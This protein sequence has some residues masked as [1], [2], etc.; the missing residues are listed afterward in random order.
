[1]GAVDRACILGVRQIHALKTRNSH[2]SVRL[3][4][5]SKRDREDALRLQEEAAKK[6]K[7]AALFAAIKSED[8]E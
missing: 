2:R 5:I 4:V 8:E 3:S 6:S 7:G 1:M